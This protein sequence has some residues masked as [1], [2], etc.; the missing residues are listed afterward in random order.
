MKKSQDSVFLFTAVRNV[1]DDY[2]DDLIKNDL[3]LPHANGPADTAA[4][5][6]MLATT[7]LHGRRLYLLKALPDGTI[8]LKFFR[9]HGNKPT[10]KLCNAKK[11]RRHI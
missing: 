10:I 5:R 11:N 2:I 9:T 8:P 1:P 7:T 3:S 6:N 4:P